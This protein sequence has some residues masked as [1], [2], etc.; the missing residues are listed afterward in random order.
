[1]TPR[2]FVTVYYDGSGLSLFPDV[3]RALAHHHGKN[4]TKAEF[5]EALGA[6]ARAGI[7]KCQEKSAGGATEGEG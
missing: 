1:M 2:K 3:A 5:W 7:R 4:L 6:N